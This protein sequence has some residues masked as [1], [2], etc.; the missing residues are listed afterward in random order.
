LCILCF[1]VLLMVFWGLG[2]CL[3]SLFDASGNKSHRCLTYWA[4]TNLALTGLRV[5]IEG[6]EY[7]DPKQRYIFMPNHASFLDILLAFA[8]IPFNFRIITKEKIFCI[9]LMGWAL[10]WSRQIPMDRA[11]PRKG[12][13]SL[14]QALNLLQEGIS[15]VVFPEGTRTLDGKIKDFKATL[16]ILPIRSGIPVV[17]VRIEGTFDAL[18]RGSI[19]LNPVP[20]KITFYDPVP[21]GSFKD[22][23]RWRYAKKVQEVLSSSPDPT[24][25]AS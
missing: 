6:L 4:K 9:P 3:A 15:I 21:A 20:L 22:R 2:S 12:L 23:D 11:N 25:S 7:L 24:L 13:A 19:L 5:Q 8:Y 18:K 10:K 17:P 16:F 14:R 1:F